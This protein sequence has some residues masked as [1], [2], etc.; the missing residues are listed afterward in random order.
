M[1]KKKILWVILL[2]I[3]IVAGVVIV[4]VAKPQEQKNIISAV[5]SEKAGA[6]QNIN[7]TSDNISNNT[8]EMT[9]DIGQTS[10]MKSAEALE[11]ATTQLDDGVL[12]VIKG[13][14]NTTADIVI[15]DNYFDT[16]ISD[17]MLNPSS[18]DGKTIEIEG[19]YLLNYPYTFVGRYST[20]NLCAYCPQG[21]SYLE[22]V[23]DGI[24]IDLTEEESREALDEEGITITDEAGEEIEEPT[25]LEGDDGTVDFGDEEEEL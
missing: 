23:W 8:S 10:L 4:I 3:V 13:R 11:T 1:N 19:M 7:E 21:Y 15:G 20:A 25:E 16:Q 5:G 9:N 2:I 14:E 22:Y 17:M 24:D 6:S 18:Y 12:Y